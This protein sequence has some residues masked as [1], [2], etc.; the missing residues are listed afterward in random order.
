MISPRLAGAAALLLLSSFLRLPC[1]A[2]A[3]PPGTAPALAGEP[4]RGSSAEAAGD[5]S[6]R[7]AAVWDLDTVVEIAV[8]R[9]P[10]VSQADADTRAAAARKGQA[11]SAYYPTVNLS[12]GYSRNRVSVSSFGGADRSVTINNDSVRGSL[13]QVLADFGRRG[14]E[15]DRTEAL[16][17]ASRESGRSVREDVA[18]AAKAAYFDV[19]RTKRILEVD[20]QTVAQRESLLQQAKAFYEAGIRA[21]I[22]VARAEANLFQAR[23]ELTAAENALRVARITLLNRMGIDGPR[24]FELRD[25]PAAET[26]PGSLED[27]I[28]EAEERRPELRALRDQERAA[29]SALQGARAEY[30]PTLTGTGGYGYASS[31]FPLLQGY[32]L[33]VRLNVPVFSGFLTRE[34]V[35]EAQASLAST[36]FAVADLRRRI[37]LEVEQAA[38]AVR[39]A[40]ERIEARRKE[41]DA[42]G[43][44]LRLA[45][46][47]YEV[48]AGDIIEMIDAQVQM[49]RADTD[50]IEAQYDY[51]LS[52]A[53]L[54][55]AMGR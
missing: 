12:T 51:R 41:R 25:T 45:T 7:P 47:R 29:V 55:R 33:S 22:D 32:D 9:H 19:L 2:G 8:A 14:A 4:G 30:Y 50:E 11:E 35:K 53:T 42:S 27:W 6:A 24:D 10:L 1:A 43:E 16:L 49:A 23:A 46:G 34:Q 3:P 38:L 21:R 13:T 31:D 5:D 39:E 18:F 36:R 48:G 28:R 26:L 40:S 52:V 20:R 17:A 54:Q 37:R 44:N 15:A